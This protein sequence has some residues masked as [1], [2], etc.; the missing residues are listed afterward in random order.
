MLILCEPLVTKSARINTIR[1]R[2]HW[3]AGVTGASS[4]G[5]VRQMSGRVR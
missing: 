5:A 1:S 4:V 2:M 3:R